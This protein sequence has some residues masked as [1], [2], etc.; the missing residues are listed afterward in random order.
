[1]TLRTTLLTSATLALIVPAMWAWPSHAPS[2]QA[3]LALIALG[4]L[5]TGVAYILYF[6][7]IEQAGAA[8]ALAVTFAVP[9]FAV[10]YGSLFLAEPV[11]GWMLFCGAVIVCGTALSTGLIAFGRKR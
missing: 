1:M 4:V 6:R 3:W 5:C 8:R 9:V 10:V 2:L 7:L 11:T